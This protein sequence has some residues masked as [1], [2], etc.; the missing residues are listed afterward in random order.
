MPKVHR[1]KR[2]TSKQKIKPVYMKI[3]RKNLLKKG[4]LI[5]NLVIS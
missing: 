3:K 1:N 2:N 5:L 4:T